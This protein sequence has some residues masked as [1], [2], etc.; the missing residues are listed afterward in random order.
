MQYLEVS[1]AI[2]HIYDIRRQRVNNSVLSDIVEHCTQNGFSND[3]HY[4]DCYN[5]IRML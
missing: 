2:R 4:S 3:F 1:S 5:S